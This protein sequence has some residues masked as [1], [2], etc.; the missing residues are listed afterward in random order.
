MVAKVRLLGA[1]DEVLLKGTLTPFGVDRAFE[2]F[3]ALPV[4]QRMEVRFDRVAPDSSDGGL[5]NGDPVA[6]EGDS[7]HPESA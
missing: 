2:R 1:S 7:G 4:A 6:A 3:V 5:G